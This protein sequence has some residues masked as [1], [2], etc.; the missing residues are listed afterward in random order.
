M[1]S[2]QKAELNGF[3]IQVP[4]YLKG[5]LQKTTSRGL[6][7]EVVLV[8]Q[9]TGAERAE[10]TFGLAAGTGEVTRALQMGFIKHVLAFGAD[11]NHTV[12][13]VNLFLVLFSYFSSI[14]NEMTVL[15]LYHLTL[16]NFFFFFFIFRLKEW[17]GINIKLPKSMLKI[18]LI[19]QV[20]LC[21]FELE[22][23]I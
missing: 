11:V 14:R 21:T 16:S 15:T 4:L 23:L 6:Q 19:Q 18:Y 1:Q 20:L 10:C 12:Q 2:Y 3:N 7:V 22:L 13:N 8:C 17:K 9:A 5:L